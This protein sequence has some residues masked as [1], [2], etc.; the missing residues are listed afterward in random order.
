[1]DAVD[2]YSI[3]DA[4]LPKFPVHEVRD[5][6]GLATNITM[7]SALLREGNHCKNLGFPSARKSRTWIKHMYNSS[8]CYQGTPHGK[9][10]QGEA[11]FDSRSPTDQEWFYR[12]VVRTKKQM[13]QVLFQNEALT[14]TQV[15]GLSAMLNNA[16]AGSDNAEHKERLEELMTYV[17]LWFG[18]GLQGEEV[19]LLSLKGLCYFWDEIRSHTVP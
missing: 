17:V 14:S 4:L 16:W 19:P 1:M 18:A 3:G 15:M 8:C 11:K 5:R 13:E 2:Q 12:F 9:E 10:S 6:A 7:T